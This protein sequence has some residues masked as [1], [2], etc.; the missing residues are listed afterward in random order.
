[1]I[2]S[3]VILF[4]VLCSMAWAQ[5][6]NGAND[7]TSCQKETFLTAI[8]TQSKGT[9]KTGDNPCKSCTGNN[10]CQ[11]SWAL[12]NC[13]GN[14]LYCPITKTCKPC[15][16][17]YK[18]NNKNGSAKPPKSAMITPYLDAAQQLLSRLRGS[19]T[20]PPAY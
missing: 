6:S 7:P 5:Q 18:C 8:R 15:P 10:Y 13:A 14:N 1:M 11:C 3:R 9:F 20:A 2:A 4:L 17:G 12:T 19:H 16:P